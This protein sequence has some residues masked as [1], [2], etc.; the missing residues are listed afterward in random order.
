[1]DDLRA[2]EDMHAQILTVQLLVTAR[3]KLQMGHK[4]ISR[5]NGT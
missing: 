4:A 3:R 2:R 5:I 1:M